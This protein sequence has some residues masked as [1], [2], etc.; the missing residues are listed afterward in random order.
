MFS[1]FRNCPFT[2]LI[3]CFEALKVFFGYHFFRYYFFSLFPF[4]GISSFMCC[5]ALWHLMF[6][7]SSVH[8][9]SFFQISDSQN[10][11]F[12]LPHPKVH[13]SFLM[14]VLTN[15]G[16]LL[17]I[18]YSIPCPFPLWKFSL[19]PCYD[20][21]LFDILILFTHSCSCFIWFWLFQ[22]I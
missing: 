12:K 2:F 20:F 17:V 9:S 1:Y 16:I 10:E 22:Y 11:Q 5:S 13:R 21:V 7:I 8:F 3:M 18:F 4:L 19:I 6:P 15:C 14:P